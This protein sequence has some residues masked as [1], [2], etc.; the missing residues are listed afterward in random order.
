M[1]LYMYHPGQC[2]LHGPSNPV[3]LEAKSTCYS[4]YGPGLVVV[5]ELALGPIQV[6]ESKIVALQSMLEQAKCM[7]FVRASYMYL[8][9]M[10]RKIV[11]MSLAL[12]PVFPFIMA[13]TI[14]SFLHDIRI[15]AVLV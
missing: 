7:P 1:W 9:S 6:P 8:A 11:F 13:H 2:R 12:G 10:L 4:V 3:C 5:V 14:R 15:K